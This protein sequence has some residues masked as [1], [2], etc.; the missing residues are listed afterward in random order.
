M[1]QSNKTTIHQNNL[2]NSS[3]FDASKGVLVPQTTDIQQVSMNE[4]VL[5]NILGFT[6]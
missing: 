1:T 3:I 5:I 6:R 2:N 4:K